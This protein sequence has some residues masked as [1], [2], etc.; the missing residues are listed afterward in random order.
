MKIINEKKSAFDTAIRMLILF[1]VIGWCSM[2]M[3]PFINIILWTIILAMV[4]YPVHKKLSEKIGDKPKLASVIII[5]T[6]LIIILIPTWLLIESLINEIKVLKTSYDNGTLVMPTPDENV[7]ELPIIGGKIFEMWQMATYHSDKLIIK[8]QSQLI[9]FGS[10][11]ASGIVNAASSIF[12]ILISLFIA[13]YIL[14]SKKS[15]QGLFNFFR[16]IGGERGDK[17]TEIT[18]KTVISVVKGILGESLIMA[19]LNGIVFL[20]AGVPYAGIWTMLAFVF[21]VLQLPILIITIPIIIYLFTVNSIVVAV[22][23]TIVLLLVSLSD[24]VLT[25]LMLG[26][27]APVPLAV[28]FVGVIGGFMLSG[29]IGL[30]TGAII[31]SVGYTLFIDWIRPDKIES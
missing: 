8:Y 18:Y 31:M 11:V 20:M 4:L 12:Q 1:L 6:I 9:S 19:I 24:N 28:I 2:I 30:F 14:T 29:F 5:F 23:W 10:K 3:F 16:K 15:E 17:L 22:I 27:G 25:P 7:K 13:G 21:A 26:K